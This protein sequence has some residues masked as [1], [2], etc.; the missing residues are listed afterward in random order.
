MDWLLRY[1][2]TSQGMHAATATVYTI[3][4]HNLTN[5]TMLAVHVS[6]IGKLTCTAI[7]YAALS[8]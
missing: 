7:Q 1:I 5:Y 8:V 3:H 2:L 4:A 6:N